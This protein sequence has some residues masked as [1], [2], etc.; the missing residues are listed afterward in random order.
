[1]KQ[2]KPSELINSLLVAKLNAVF[3]VLCFLTFSFPRFTTLGVFLLIP[4]VLLFVFDFLIVLRDL[5]RAGTRVRAALAIVLWLPVLLLFG[6]I[7]VWEGPLYITVRS[8]PPVLQIRG[9]AM[10]CGLRIYGP[11]QEKAEW[12][13]DDIGVIWS[14]EHFPNHFPIEAKV[15]YG[16]VPPEFVQKAPVDNGSPA[17]LSPGAT[18]G[19]EIER[20]MGGPEYFS[21]RN[22][23]IKEGSP[24][25]D[26]CWG[27]LKV[28]ERNVPAMVRVDCKTRE[29]LPMSDRA[30]QRLRDYRENRIPFY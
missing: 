28:P 23:T 15:V 25:S 30:K 14:I 5:W 10:F 27:E 24:V 19:L 1:M 29:P 18:Y 22:M 7:Q 12:R 6:M 11:E 17:P 20:C 13:E 9:L 3:S 26:L 21:L 2:L 16:V 4:I 8:G